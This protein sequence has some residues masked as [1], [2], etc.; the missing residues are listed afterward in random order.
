MRVCN[1]PGCPN[2]TEASRCTTHRQ[3]YEQQ[4]GSRQQRGYDAEHDKLRA[5]W[6]QLVEG[7]TVTCWR[8]GNLIHPG[9]AWDLGHDDH[10]RTKYRGPEHAN[11]C[12]RAAAGRASHRK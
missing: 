12:N 5:R 1:I 6:A 11:Q 2:P 7:G 10:D 8:C 9:T 4:R 3:Q